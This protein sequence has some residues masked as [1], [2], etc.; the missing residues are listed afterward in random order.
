M[1]NVL[2]FS[3]FAWPEGGAGVDRS[4]AELYPRL[5]AAGHGQIRLVALAGRDAPRREERDGVLILRARR[6]P[7]DRL[8]GLQAAVSLDAWR[9]GMRAARDRKPDLVHAHTLFY[10]SSLVAAAV[11]RRHRV[12][13]LL[14]LHVGDLGA[15]PRPY[16]V[17]SQAY[18]RTVGRGLLRAAR[19]IICVSDD[20]RRHAGSFG[21]S[22]ATLAVV[23]NGVDTARFVPRPRSPGDP[24]VL[25]CVGRLIAN[26]GPQHLLEGVARLRRQGVDARLLY[27]GGG[28]LE[29]RLRRRAHALGMDDRIRFLGRRQ[30][31]DALLAEADVFVRPSLTDGMSLSVLEAMAAGLP[32]VATDVSG[33]RELIDDGI[34]G[35]VTPPG[36]V[37]ALADGVARL[38]NDPSA[39]ER[40][41]ANARRRALAFDWSIV[42][43]RTAEEMGRA[44]A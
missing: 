3:D 1:I 38:L 30:D 41:G 35:V 36:S 8:T 18:E 10:H 32:V 4:L 15:L 16:R 44:L 27:V 43:E 39:R 22:E 40:M 31:V 13:L 42:A 5:V 20:V 2:A 37:S 34:S 33:T 17:V 23:P 29:H 6:L 21:I 9:V 11:A 24:P 28:P 7:L 14:T 12:P 19:R 26:K 25:M